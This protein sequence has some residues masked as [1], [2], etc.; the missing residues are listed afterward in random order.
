[1][2]S[3]GY[4]LIEIIVI[5]AIM[6]IVLLIVSQGIIGIQAKNLQNTC[7]AHSRQLS[8][9]ILIYMNDYDGYFPIIAVRA[10][11]GGR[12]WFDTI[13][14]VLNTRVT[15]PSVTRPGKIREKW[16]DPHS[17]GYA[18]ND[19][20]NQYTFIRRRP[21]YTPYSDPHINPSLTVLLLESRSCI[22]SLTT[23][24]I[25]TYDGEGVY[26]R[27]YVK[28]IASQIEGGNRHQGG[29]NY[30]FADGHL[31]WFRHWQLRTG[32]KGDGVHPGFGL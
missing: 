3:K 25:N 30:S 26:C 18:M 9:G 7:L 24:D 27:S 17:S 28:E 12:Y 19:R 2:S 5:I 20:L 21:K 11:S 23:P 32:E 10:E 14:E 4:T 22:T 1:M 6:A 16:A 15:C 31:K 29:A 13:T 8:S